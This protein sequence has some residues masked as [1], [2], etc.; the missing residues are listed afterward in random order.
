[1]YMQVQIPMEARRDIRSLKLESWV[2][3][4]FL[5]W[6]LGTELGCSARALHPTVELALA[7]Q[8]SSFKKKKLLKIFISLFVGGGVL[9][10]G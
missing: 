3:V 4:S 5:M 2:V 10:R 9:G 8:S 1:M 7:S 6:V